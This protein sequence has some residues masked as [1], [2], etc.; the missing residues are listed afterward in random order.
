MKNLRQFKVIFL[1]QGNV[2]EQNL[3][4]YITQVIF[5]I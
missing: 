3:I 1:E 2:V 4:R 5:E